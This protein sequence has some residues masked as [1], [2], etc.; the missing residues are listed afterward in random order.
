MSSYQIKCWLQVLSKLMDY[1]RSKHTPADTKWQTIIQQ[2]SRHLCLWSDCLGL[3]Q[4]PEQ[5]SDLPLALALLAQHDKKQANIWAL[6]LKT[7]L[8]DVSVQLK[9]P[10]RLPMLMNQIMAE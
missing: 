2:Q 5:E 7:V 6:R 1:Q 3:C 10:A 4:L 9:S 8:P